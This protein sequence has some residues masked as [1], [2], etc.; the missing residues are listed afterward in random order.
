MQILKP[1]ATLFQLFGYEGKDVWAMKLQLPQHFCTG[2]LGEK[3]ATDVRTALP[4][5]S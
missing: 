4:S 3:P 2:L 5:A 1:N